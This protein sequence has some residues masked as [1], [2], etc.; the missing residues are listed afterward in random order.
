MQLCQ[1]HKR[2]FKA[3]APLY[4][5]GGSFVSLGIHIA[6]KF[7]RRTKEK[8][9]TKDKGS[10][11]HREEEKMR[12]VFFFFS[13]LTGL[14]ILITHFSLLVTSIPSKSVT[15]TMDQ[16]NRVFYVNKRFGLE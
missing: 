12:Y 4:L 16:S 6:Q 15:F 11:I 3:M 14:R 1:I 8:N 2:Q 7:Q 10:Q 13:L 5:E 9:K